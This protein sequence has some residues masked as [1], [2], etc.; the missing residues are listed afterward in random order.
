MENKPITKKQKAYD[1]MKSRII[2]G[3][4]APGQRIVINQLVKELSTSAIPIR[5]AVRQLEAE[6]LIDYQNNIGPVVTPID[7][8]EYV[9]TLSVLAVMEGYATALSS[10]HGI[11][12][13]KIAELTMKNQQMKEAI[14][15]FDFQAF[16]Q[17]NRDFHNLIYL[18]CN[19]TY[20][21]EEIH[22][23]WRKLD[24]IRRAGSAFHPKR[25]IASIEEH[26]Q[27]IHLLSQNKEFETI[28]KAAR[29]HK[30]NTKDSFLSQQHVYGEAFLQ[31][32]KV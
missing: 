18:F 23:L 4:Y 31:N 8:H 9:D 19:N 24:S 13:G 22:R 5:E 12:E 21:V 16:G 1:Y 2:E 29:N 20:L 26:K 7:K 3:H 27:L 15:A 28:E 11:P 17:L 10:Q 32:N 30:L 25:A 6:G 14:E